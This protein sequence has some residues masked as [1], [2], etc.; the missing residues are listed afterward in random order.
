VTANLDA[1]TAT[2]LVNGGAAHFDVELDF[3]TG[4]R[5]EK[6]AIGDLTGDGRPDLVTTDIGPDTISVHANTPGLCAVQDVRRTT[7]VLAKQTL[8][9]AHCRVG[10][11]RRVYSN[12]V[13]RGRVISQRPGPYTVLPS[14]ASI[15]LVLSRGRK[16]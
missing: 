11:V 10:R 12:S 1:S 4:G 14:G 15:N 3:R 16:R 9:R 13:G 6:A 2:V 5:P 7:L 8:A